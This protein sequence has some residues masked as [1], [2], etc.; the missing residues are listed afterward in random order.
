MTGWFASAR[1]AVRRRRAAT[2]LFRD[3]AHLNAH[4][5]NDVGLPAREV[6]EGARRIQRR[7][8]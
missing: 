3:T 1:A 5:L 2:F 7:A 8:A 6:R 4:L